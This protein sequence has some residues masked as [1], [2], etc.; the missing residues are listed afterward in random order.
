MFPL[1]KTMLSLSQ[2][3]LTWLMTGC[4]LLGILTVLTC[5][6]GLTWLSARAVHISIPYVGTAVHVLLGGIYTVVG[7]FM[8]P[9]L[10]ILIAG[11]F[12]ETVIHRVESAHYTD[13]RSDR[14]PRF[15]PDLKHDILFTLTAVGL[16]V[17]ILPF[18]MIGIGPFLSVLLNSYL[19]GREFFENA[20]GYHMGKAEARRLGR[21]HKT[22]VYLGGFVITCLTLIPVINLFMPI[23]A[24]VWMVHLYHSPG[25]KDIGAK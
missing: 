18:Y 8:L 20:A 11:M 6:G 10:V 9:S 7:W 25:I 19:L 21:N 1:R 22:A 14:S 13:H 2:D 17:C 23:I 16:N 12:Q 4:A 15:W 24:I 3:H 5:V